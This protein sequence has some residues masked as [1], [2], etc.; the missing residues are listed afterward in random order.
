MAY[1]APY[2]DETG[3]HI[4]SYSDIRDDLINTAKAIYGADLYLGN[5]S[6]DYQFISAL[7]DKINDTNLIALSVYNNRSPVTAIGSALDGVVKLNGISRDAATYST[8]T[9]LLTGTAGAVITN[10]VVSTEAGTKWSLPA[11]VTLNISGEA[12]TTATSQ[13]PGPIVAD[14]GS[15]INIDTPT[16]GWTSV[17]NPTAAVLGSDTETNAQLRARQAVSTSLPALTVIESTKGAIAA[18]PAVTRY[19]VYENFT[20]ATDSDGIPSHS[21][22]CIVE[23]GSDA[24]VAQAIFNKK[25]PG[26]GTHGDV[27]TNIIDI[28]GTV[29]PIKFFRPTYVDVDAVITVKALNGYTTA[30]TQAV[31]DKLAEFLN[32]LDIGNDI[33]YSSCY[34]AALQANASLASPTFSVTG[35]T[36]GKHGMSQSTTDIVTTF[37]EVA[38]GNTNYVTVNV[39]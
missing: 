26:C 2:I 21:I 1:E 18:V 25:G 19:K 30:V 28:Y 31:K 29:T 17:T 36:I 14:V 16:L 13:I 20:S 3:M 5:D 39:V 24:D 32:S 6:Q 22:A 10:G 9:V 33:S 15:I 38:R 27:A 23:N 8:A 4:P 7:A 34:G 12:A 35:L 11:S 37:K